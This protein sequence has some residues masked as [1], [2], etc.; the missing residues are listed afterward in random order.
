MSAFMTLAAVL[1]LAQGVWGGARIEMTVGP[2][3]AAIRAG[4]PRHRFG[5][6]AA[7]VWPGR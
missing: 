1:S 6:L 3:G 4:E 5:G 7:G 2:E